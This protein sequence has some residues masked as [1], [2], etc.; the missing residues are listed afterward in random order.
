MYRLYEAFAPK[1]HGK[2][3]VNGTVP[4]ADVASNNLSQRVQQIP[5]PPGQLVV[6]TIAHLHDLN[7]LFILRL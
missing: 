7:I 2:S 5:P 1:P 4:A 3:E 6:C